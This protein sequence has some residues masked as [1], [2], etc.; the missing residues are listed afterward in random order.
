LV[1]KNRARKKSRTA[2]LIVDDEIN[3]AKTLAMVL[4]QQGYAATFALSGQ[5]AIE[6][7]SRMRPPI[8]IVDVNLPEMDGIEVALEICDRA[9]DCK[10]L[11]MTGDPDSV[12]RLEKARARG[13]NFDVLGKPIPPPELLEKLEA[14]M[15]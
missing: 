6:I 12:E 8:A 1:E 11:L 10:I 13:I 15:R 4:E 3:I 5:S 14:L 7:A 2:I 9:P